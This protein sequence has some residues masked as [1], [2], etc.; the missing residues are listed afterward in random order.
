MK[1]KFSL[2]DVGINLV[3][4]LKLKPTRFLILLMHGELGKEVKPKV[5]GQVPKYIFDSLN[6]ILNV[7]INNLLV[8][9]SL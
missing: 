6:K 2:V 4:F 7:V 1:Y 8:L 9:S 3:V 5:I